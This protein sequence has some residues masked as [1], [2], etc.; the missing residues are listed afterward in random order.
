MSIP[1]HLHTC[2]YGLVVRAQGSQSNGH[3]FKSPRRQNNI[4][5]VAKFTSTHGGTF[6]RT[7]AAV[8]CCLLRMR[9]C[10]EKEAIIINYIKKNI[11]VNK[12]APTFLPV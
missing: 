6:C 4:V 9:A 12:N 7:V 8:N 10:L 2:S 11:P 5:G 3:G 1:E